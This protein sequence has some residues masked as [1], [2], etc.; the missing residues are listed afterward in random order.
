MLTKLLLRPISSRWATS[1]PACIQKTCALADLAE[2]FILPITFFKPAIFVTMS[3]S[4]LLIATNQ[5]GKYS[6]SGFS[7]CHSTNCNFFE[8]LVLLYPALRRFVTTV[9]IML[10]TSPDTARSTFVIQSPIEAPTIS[11]TDLLL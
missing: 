9:P 5:E 11:H 10:V 3:F 1:F 7:V 4:S 8:E 2:D 6:L